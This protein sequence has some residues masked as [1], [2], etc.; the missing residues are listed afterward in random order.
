MHKGNLQCVTQFEPSISLDKIFGNINRHPYKKLMLALRRK[1]RENLDFYIAHLLVI[2]D[3]LAEHD[4]YYGNV[5][6]DNIRLL[7]NGYLQLVDLRKAH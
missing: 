4:V 1:I 3:V 5:K 7:K 2:F 6:L